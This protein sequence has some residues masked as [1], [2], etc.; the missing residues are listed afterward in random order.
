MH[1]K[2]QDLIKQYP[3]ICNSRDSQFTL[4]SVS[5]FLYSVHYVPFMPIFLYSRASVTAKYK[6]MC[7]D[8]HTLAGIRLIEHIKQVSYKYWSFTKHIVK[9]TT[10]T[11][12]G[13]GIAT[14]YGLDNRG[15]GV[16]VLVGQDM[17]LLHVV[18]T[19]SGTH[20]ASYSIGIKAI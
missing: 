5:K 12:I 7:S 6:S 11:C 3:V 9:L 4:H 14:G 20:I 2:K 17:F 1:I 15:V 16:W 13:I 19:G 18:Q 8:I 10:G